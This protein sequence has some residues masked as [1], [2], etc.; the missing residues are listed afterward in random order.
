MNSQA[1]IAL[2]LGGTKLAS[3]LFA[4]N[5]RKLGKLSVPLETRSG[6]AVGE[7]II[8]QV[9]RLQHAA[10]RRNLTVAAVGICV[11][12][13]ANPKSGRVWAPNIGG[14]DDYPLRAEI[15]SAIS[16]SKVKV[17]VDSDRATSILGEAWQGAVRGCRDAIF[18]AVG[19]GIGAGILVDG[20]VLRGAQNIA[21]AIG[22]L[23]LGRPFKREY[24]DCGFFE[25][26]ASGEGIAKVAKELLGRRRNYRG[27]LR[28][29]SH[30][31]A[32][33][34]FAAF[35]HSDEIAKEV[36][37]QAI[38][39]WGMASANLI[40][41]FNPEKIVFGGGLFGP[42]T[43][44]LDAIATEGRRWAQP[45]AVQHVKFAA[46][47]LGSDAAL[48]GAGYLALRSVRL[49]DDI[50]KLRNANS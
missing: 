39:F 18:L 26:H 37:A 34:V 42:A 22:W 43:Q 3:A 4:S 40:S 47:E 48:H 24:V 11:P 31:T 10:E 27:L 29:K 20:H 32:H 14:W 41:L 5:G 49:T 23:A 6:Q 19:T 44:F 35:E 2:D 9:R 28:K 45:I 38:E 8:K 13:I 15:Q 25:S 30:L 16:N 33:D 46:S 21:G 12:G 1:V 36:F 50:A 7:L 17:V